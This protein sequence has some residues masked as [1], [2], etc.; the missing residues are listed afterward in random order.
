[1][2]AG[3]FGQHRSFS[4]HSSSLLAQ[5]RIKPSSST[6][7]WNTCFSRN[8]ARKSIN[9]LA[10]GKTFPFREGVKGR[11]PIGKLLIAVS[12]PKV[13]SWRTWLVPATNADDG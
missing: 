10:T 11:Y 1:L 4:E 12:S 7:R 13:G 8:S 9:R 2:R 5:Y 6:L 3:A